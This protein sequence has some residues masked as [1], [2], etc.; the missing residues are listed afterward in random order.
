MQIKTLSRKSPFL[1][2]APDHIHKIIYSPFGLNNGIFG[3]FFKNTVKLKKVPF[4]EQALYIM[5]K[6]KE[7]GQLKATQKG[8]LSKAF[9]IELYHQFYSNER[10]ARLPNKE[11]DMPEVTGLKHILDTAGL[12][13]KRANKFSLTKKGE[14]IIDGEKISELFDVLVGTLFNKWN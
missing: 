11:D 1:G 9:V 6:L 8:N 14:K 2:L 12:I 7:A 5:T 13:K 4:V 3:F 10:Y